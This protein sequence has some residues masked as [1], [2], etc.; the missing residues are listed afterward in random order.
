MLTARSRWQ[1][2]TLAGTLAG[3]HAGRQARWQAGTLAD[4]YLRRHAQKRICF[5]SIFR[6]QKLIYFS[7]QKRKAFYFNSHKNVLF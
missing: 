1:A 3:R 7:S 5:I 4:H 2:G 6:A